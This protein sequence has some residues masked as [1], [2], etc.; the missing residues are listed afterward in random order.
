MVTW[1]HHTPGAAHNQ[2][3]AFGTY[4]Q[5]RA[6]LDEGSYLAILRDGS[7]LRASYAFKHDHLTAHSL[8]FWPCPFAVPPDD[9]LEYSPLDATDL[10]AADWE[11]WVRFRTPMRFDYDPKAATE[12]HPVS[13]LHAQGHDC[14]IAVERPVGF[15]AF[16]QFIFR[17]FYFTDWDA[18][19]TFWPDLAHHLREQN[20]AC[21]TPYD[22]H[23]LHLGWK[24][25]TA[26][27]VCPGDDE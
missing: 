9:I 17:S 5:Y 21:L 7:V 22:M 12:N 26:A 4:A 16:V 20:Q 13:H 19:R 8:W 15:A 14:R 27:A 2:D 18:N 1:P 6:I 11:A 10:Y 23:S 24:V 25:E 3:S